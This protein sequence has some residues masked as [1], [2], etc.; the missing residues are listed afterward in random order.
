M[1]DIGLGE[2]FALGV[3]GLL[4]FGPDRLP[5][6]AA[7][8]AKFLKQIRTMAT[9][10]KQDLADSAGL[11]LNEAVDTVKGLADLHPKRLASSLM[12]DEPVAKAPPTPSPS[13]PTF[14]P[15]AT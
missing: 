15:D 10:A 1:F 5:K 3:L 14:D 2:I 9:S 12:R 13:R 4:I 6:A 7:D 11:D 8:G